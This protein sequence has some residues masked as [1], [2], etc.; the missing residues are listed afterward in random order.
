M[1]TWAINADTPLD[2]LWA[3]WVAETAN[4]RDPDTNEL[5]LGVYGG[6]HLT[7][8]FETVGAIT[9]A[10]AADYTRK[11][12]GVVM[13]Q[14]VQK[15]LSALRGF[16][17]WCEEQGYVDVAP[18]IAKP[19]RR[20]TGTRFAKRRRGKATELS[21]EEA[22]ALVEQLPEWS[23]S[24]R[25]PPFPVRARFVVAFETSLRPATLDALSVPEHYSP[26]AM[27]LRITDEIDKARFG[28][29]LPLTPEA[30]AALDQVCPQSG[31]IFGVHYYRDQLR[32][33]ADAVLPPE[34]AKTFAAYDLRHTRLTQL[35]ETG[36]LPGT[37]FMAGHVRA[38]TTALYIRPNQR[39]AERTLAG[40]GATGFGPLTTNPVRRRNRLAG[41]GKSSERLSLCEGGDL[42]PHGSNPASTSS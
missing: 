35:A 17:M 32:K 19:P 33:A 7:P 21:V 16:L 39:A 28:R 11:R 30:R 22:R 37:S 4:E 36:N 40:A 41:V 1:S 18:V 6:R 13:K 29:E 2:E 20:A 14:T 5:Y 34:R 31:L 26:G 9:T 15:E 42:N 12:L 25:V 23:G 3:R 10:R 27:S 8:F 24:R 38:T